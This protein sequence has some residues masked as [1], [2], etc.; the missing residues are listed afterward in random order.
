MNIIARLEKNSVP[1]TECGCRIWMGEVH[2]TGRIDVKGKN[3][4][5]HRVAYAAY[6]GSIPHLKQVL[7]H[8]DVPLC[9]EENHLYAGTSKDNYDDM[10]RR[11]RARWHKVRRNGRWAKASPSDAG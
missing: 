8:C 6:K 4:F 5:V 3:R 11:G 10:V 2:P 1:I 7:H 9:I